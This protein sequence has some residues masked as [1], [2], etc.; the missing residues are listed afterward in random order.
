ML[1]LAGTS[2]VAVAMIALLSW[3]GIEVYGNLRASALV[4]SLSMANI[5]DVP[6]IVG[7]ISGYRRWVDSRLKS[8]A[9]GADNA[10]REKLNASLALL[11]VDRS[12]LPYP[13]GEPA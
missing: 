3:G 2:V 8:L 7:R 11:P 4:E 10:S 13:G 5:S 1:G 12:Q 6:A 9:Q